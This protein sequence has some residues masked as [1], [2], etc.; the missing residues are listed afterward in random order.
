MHY[1]LLHY[2]DLL[3]IISVQ[4]FKLIRSIM[5]DNGNYTCEI[6]L[7]S[8]WIVIL[9]TTTIVVHYQWEWKGN[10]VITKNRSVFF[11]CCC[12]FYD[13]NDVWS[14]EYWVLFGR[15]WN[16]WS[17][18]R[19]ITTQSLLKSL[20]VCDSYPNWSRIYG[21]LKMEKGL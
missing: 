14:S 17:C 8:F 19:E 12:W 21:T 1:H 15:V 2:N 16:K 18:T 7:F 10:E 11:F 6:N 4:N 20:K 9:C 5:L 3:R 13:T